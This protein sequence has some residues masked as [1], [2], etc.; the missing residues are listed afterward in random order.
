MGTHLLS[1]NKEN[2]E[3]REG[4]KGR[5]FFQNKLIRWKLKMLSFSTESYLHSKSR[6]VCYWY[7]CLIYSVYI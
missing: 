1:R 6:T 2:S 7:V 5:R 3:W 4:L